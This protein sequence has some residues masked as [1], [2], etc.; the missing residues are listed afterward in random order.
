MKY[1]TKET[2]RPGIV[3]VH[4]DHILSDVKK[5]KA[6]GEIHTGSG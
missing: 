3:D 1:V 6:R 5:G 4:N 2:Q